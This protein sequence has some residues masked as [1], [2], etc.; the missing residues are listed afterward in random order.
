LSEPLILE[1]DGLVKRFGGVPAVNGATL[2]VAEASI[3]ALIGPNGAGKTSVFNVVSGFQRADQGHVRFGGRRIDRLPVH[4]IV[5][6]G[7]VRTFQQTKILRRM[8]VL[9]NMLVA[10]PRQ[11]GESLW[12]IPLAGPRRRRE[13]ELENRA[14]ELLRGVRLE[15]QAGAYAGT[16]SGGQRKLLEFVRVLMTEPRMVLLDEP[17]AGV[18]PAL[19]EQLLTSITAG[20]DDR[21]ITF[22]LIE[23]DLESVMAISDTVAVMSAGQVIFEGAPRDV[24][25]SIEVVDAYLGAAATGAPRATP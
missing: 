22:L 12:R 21:N 13:R 10:A 5:R 16:L 24:R 2:S 15:N 1:V 20:R 3:T 11:P 18:N 23:H 7:L 17:M 9:E 8:S 4:A 6:A 25:R 19:R 14:L